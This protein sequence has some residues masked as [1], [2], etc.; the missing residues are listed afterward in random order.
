MFK[1]SGSHSIEP[2]FWLT[3]SLTQPS[4][5][6]PHSSELFAKVINDGLNDPAYRVILGEVEHSKALLAMRWGHSEPAL[7]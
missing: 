2:S 6:S 5:H 3:D 7:F 1:V 4:E